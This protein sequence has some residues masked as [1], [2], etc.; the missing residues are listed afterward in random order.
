MFSKE[1]PSYTFMSN[2]TEIEPLGQN[3]IQVLSALR[4]Q[5][6]SF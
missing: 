2:N 3:K 6:N 5:D 1:L 4:E